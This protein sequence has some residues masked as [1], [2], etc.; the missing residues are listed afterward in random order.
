MS[1]FTKI[2]NDVMLAIGS[3]LGSSAYYVYSVLRMHARQADRCEVSAVELAEQIGMDRTSVNRVIGTL[4]EA[5]VIVNGATHGKSP[6]HVLAQPD[7]ICIMMQNPSCGKKHHDVMQKASSGD[8]KSIMSLHE[9]KT[10]KTEDKDSAREV[11]PVGAVECEP[12][13]SPAFLTFWQLY[14]KK[15]AQDGAWSEWRSLH[16]DARN[17]ILS[18]L[19]AGLKRQIAEGKFEVEYR[20]ILLPARYLKDK[21][22][23]DEAKP[24]PQIPNGHTAEE[25]PSTVFYGVYDEATNSIVRTRKR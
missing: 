2:E 20:Y 4:R 3:R 17:D 1:G 24:A 25:A 9:Y 8:A 7:A 18:A 5:G 11:A 19:M 16:L 15:E 22:W 13:Y 21:R 12:S 10:Y 6:V 14:P 23:K